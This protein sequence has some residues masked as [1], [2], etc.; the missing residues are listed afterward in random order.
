MFGL[1][2]GF[3][4]HMSTGDRSQSEILDEGVFACVRCVVWLA[5]FVLFDLLPWTKRVRVAALT[6][7]VAAMLLVLCVVPGAGLPAVAVALWAAVALALNALPQPAYAVNRLALMRIL[8]LFMTAAVALLF[9]LNVFNPVVSSAEKVQVALQAGKIYST[10][11]QKDSR[12]RAAFVKTKVLAPLAEAAKDDPDDAR[13]RILQANWNLVLWK[14]RAGDILQALACAHQAEKLDPHGA[15]GWGVEYQIRMEFAA[16]SWKPSPIRPT[17][18]R[19]WGR[20]IAFFLRKLGR[21]SV[22]RSGKESKRRS[23]IR[24]AVQ[25]NNNNEINLF[26][27]VVQYQEAAAVLER[28]LPNAPNNAAL[29]YQLAETLY[30]ARE[31]GRCREVAEETLQLDAAASH[32]L[33]TDEQRRKLDFWKALPEPVH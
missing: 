19:P 14:L 27:A 3:I 11:A 29:R 13:A 10:A 28:Y 8:P 4:I 24:A 12:V 6:L 7:G 26:V 18:A 5:A 15:G 32:P 30:K 16:R 17:P 23:R 1:V 31:D 25:A 21:L 22:P 9:L 33:L 2:L 20:P